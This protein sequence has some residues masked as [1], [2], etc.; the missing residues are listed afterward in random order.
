MPTTKTKPQIHFLPPQ[1]NA[2]QSYRPLL[3]LVVDELDRRRRE[4]RL[5]LR[6]C[7]RYYFWKTKVARMSNSINT[8]F[9]TAVC[10]IHTGPLDLERAV[11]VVRHEGRGEARLNASSADRV[12]A[13]VAQLGGLGEEAAGDTQAVAVLVAVGTQALACVY[14][15]VG[16]FQKKGTQSISN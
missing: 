8:Y 15:G 10:F 12:Q 4:R 14:V 11:E 9:I 16:L 6:A 2:R 1:Q 3:E 7:C 13:H 5:R